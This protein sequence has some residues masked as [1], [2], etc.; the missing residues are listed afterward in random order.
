MGGLR[1]SHEQ[2]LA[3]HHTV[4]NVIVMFLPDGGY[5]RAHVGGLV[6]RP[7]PEGATPWDWPDWRLDFQGPSSG[8][9]VQTLRSAV[10]EAAAR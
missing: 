2:L 5:D 1:I 3:L 9:L 6:F 10:D 7:I 8:E 4:P